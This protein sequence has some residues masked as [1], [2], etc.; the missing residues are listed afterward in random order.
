VSARTLADEQWLPASFDDVVKSFLDSERDRFERYFELS[1]ADRDL[2]ERIASSTATGG[3]LGPTLRRSLLGLIR[4]GLFHHVP[5]TTKWFS[6]A[7]RSSYLDEIRVIARCG[8]DDPADRN[9]LRKVAGRCP[10]ITLKEAPERWKP[11][12]LWGHSEDG[13][14]VILE[15]NHRLVAYAA[16]GDMPNVCVQSFIGLSPDICNWHPL[17]PRHLGYPRH[18]LMLRQDRNS[19]RSSGFELH[20]HMGF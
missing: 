11:V 20:S 12:V 7:L 3:E 16:N 1:E 8:W 18:P 14:F 19:Y 10:R 13:P 5:P 2:I 17:D 6:V 4:F 15:G 9:E